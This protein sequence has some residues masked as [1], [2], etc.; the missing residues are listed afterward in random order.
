[1]S[2]TRLTVYDLLRIT[3]T[4]EGRAMEEAARSR[5]DSIC[6]VRGLYYYSLAKI[7]LTL[8]RPQN[9]ARICRHPRHLATTAFWRPTSRSDTAGRTANEHG[10]ERI[11][12]SF[13]R[14]EQLAR[15]SIGSA[16]KAS[17][18]FSPRNIPRHQTK[19]INQASQT[20]HPRARAR[21][22][23]TPTH[24]PTTNATSTTSRD[25]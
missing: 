23:N 22:P 24:L 9:R 14:L 15:G 11:C 7:E 17:E 20:K 1:M 8:Y 12:S 19:Q 13:W 16:R 25:L 10:L 18:D 4:Y 3:Y 5:S 6:S 2:T 21:K